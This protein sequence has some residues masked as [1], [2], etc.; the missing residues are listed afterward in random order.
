MLKNYLCAALLAICP[1]LFAQH[2]PKGLTADEQLLMDDFI[3]NRIFESS[4]RA[5]NSPPNMPVRTMAEWEEIQGLQ[6][7]WDD[8]PDMLI[9]IVRAA[10]QECRV[11]IVTQ[12]ANSVRNT[13]L[14]EGIDTA[15]ITYLNAPFNSVWCRD[16][17][18]N[19]VYGN[20]VD[21]L[22]IVDW[23]YNRPSRTNDD[24]VPSALGNSLNIPVYAMATA[25]YRLVHTGGNF[26]SDGMGTAFSSELIIDENPNYTTAQIDTLMKKF[27]GINRYIKMEKLPYDGIHH[28]DMHMKLLNEETL[29]VGEYPPGIADGPQ[30]EA[31]IQYV[32]SNFQN[33]F[34]KPYKIIR[35][36]MP[37][38][39]GQW[40]DGSGFYLTHTNASFI[41]KTVI[42]PTYN[43]PS[44]TNALR[45]YREALPGYKV[46][47][48]NSNSSIPASGALHCITKE[49]GVNKPLRI[50]HE[51]LK[52]TTANTTLNITAVIEH[53]SGI[54][55]AKVYYTTDTAQAFQFA[56]MIALSGNGKIWQGTIPSQ[57]AGS[58]VFYYIAAQANS[59][60]Q[61]VRPI[62]APKGWWKF[63][64]LDSAVG[65]E[66]TK[67]TNLLVA[68]PYP[69]PSK[70]ITHISLQSKGESTLSITCFDYL[71]KEIA[72]IAKNEKIKAGA[73]QYFI[74]TQ[75]WASGV[76]YLQIKTN[77]ESVVKKLVVR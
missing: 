58:T 6:I 1:S 63:K 23:K 48:I 71:G 76:Y 30:I 7:T 27:M 39:N 10:K 57:A 47:G 60:K 75:A 51:P 53:K 9:E 16:Y 73:H 49:L 69:N 25:P 65:I 19:T 35:V 44:D 31:N 36:P 68:N 11:Y 52:D 66:N 3:H 15:N 14:S 50:V 4:S 18:G 29:L 20:S 5:I 8:Y 74:D 32:L 64:I 2:L 70:G 43:V 34:G 22:L 17:G 46:V 40:P 37:D 24:V 59:G 72:Q 67:N 41:N 12:N 21:S 55:S 38:D 28:I 26:M 56:D 13:L 33:A 45:I 77:T 61:Q 42:V 62:I 54:A